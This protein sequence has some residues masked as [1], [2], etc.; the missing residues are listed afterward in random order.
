MIIDNNNDNSYSPAIANSSSYNWYVNNG[1]GSFSKNSL[2][3]MDAAAISVQLDKSTPPT[4]VRHP[5]EMIRK[6]KMKKWD[7][8]WETMFLNNV[9]DPEDRVLPSLSYCFFKVFTLFLLTLVENNF[10]LSRSAPMRLIHPE[11]NNNNENRNTV[12][13]C[14]MLLIA[15]YILPLSRYLTVW[16]ITFGIAVPSCSTITS[17]GTLNTFEVEGEGSNSHSRYRIGSDMWGNELHC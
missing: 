8:G 15:E 6:T 13:K 7:R 4:C 3:K 1:S 9:S 16:E 10:G 14:G 17:K 5:S 11:N 12:G 2:N